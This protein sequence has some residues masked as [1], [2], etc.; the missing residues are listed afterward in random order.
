MAVQPAATN[1]EMKRRDEKSSTWF[2][3]Q[4]L[5]VDT[6]DATYTKPAGQM[7]TVDTKIGPPGTHLGAPLFGKDLGR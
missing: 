3:S 5:C 6:G 4:L 1:H 2:L 7:T